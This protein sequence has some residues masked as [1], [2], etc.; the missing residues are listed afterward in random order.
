ME[1]N[2]NFKNTFSCQMESGL[3]RN[4]VRGGKQVWRPLDDVGGREWLIVGSS[5]K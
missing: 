1:K 5:R 3:K 4:K 2:K